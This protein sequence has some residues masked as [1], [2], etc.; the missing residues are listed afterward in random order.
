MLTGFGKPEPSNADVAALA[1]A[2]AHAPVVKPVRNSVS[3]FLLMVRQII[4]FQVV[5]KSKP[6]FHRMA[7]GYLISAF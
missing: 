7:A 5:M 3:G 4:T 6:P 2:V 1:A